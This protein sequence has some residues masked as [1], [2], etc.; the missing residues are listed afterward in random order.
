MW[1][2]GRSTSVETVAVGFSSC[3]R[4]SGPTNFAGAG[5]SKVDAMLELEKG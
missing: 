4:Y 1:T 5:A 2:L 3:G